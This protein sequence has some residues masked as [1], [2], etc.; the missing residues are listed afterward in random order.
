MPSA[1]K[2]QRE[3]PKKAQPQ[4]R[5]RIVIKFRDEVNLPYQKGAER[6]L[7]ELGLAPWRNIVEAAPNAT[8]EPVFVSVPEERVR[9]LVNTARQRTS[10]YR[11]LNFFSFFALAATP[12]SD[13]QAV[14]RELKSW[15]IV[16]NAYIDRGPSTPPAV[17]AGDDPRSAYQGYL[18]AAPIGIDAHY[19]WLWPGGD[20]ED[21]GFVDLEYGWQFEHED[22]AAQDITLISGENTSYVEY[23]RHGCPRRRM[24]GRQYPRRDR[25]YSEPRIDSRGVRDA[26]RRHLQYG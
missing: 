24:R 15:S 10:S 4:V 18:S 8:L 22:L 13:L 17:N 9:E 26:R 2:P 7:N 20:G 14:L 21:R 1:K 25:H 11:P 12:G 5:P 19:A 16:E 3:G 23:P 6:V